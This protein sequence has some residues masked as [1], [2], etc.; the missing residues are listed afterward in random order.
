VGFGNDGDHGTM[1]HH[2]RKSLFFG[3]FRRFQGRLSTH[4]E[5]A[6]SV[7]TVRH[8]VDL[9]DL[10]GRGLCLAIAAVQ[11]LALTN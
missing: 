2:L 11:W 4:R 8:P 1:T 3:F 10:V 9:T 6:G 7:V 5:V